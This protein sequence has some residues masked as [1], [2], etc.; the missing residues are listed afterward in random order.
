MLMLVDRKTG[1]GLGV[2]LYDSEEVMR[3]G[4]DDPGVRHRDVR[5][6]P[7]HKRLTRRGEGSRRLRIRLAL[8]NWSYSPSGIRSSRRSSSTMRSSSSR[9]A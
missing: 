4:D 6:Q 2:T 9:L 1:K 8:S 5:N 7:K 3:R